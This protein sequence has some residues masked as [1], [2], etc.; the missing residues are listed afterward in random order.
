MD[1]CPRKL[2]KDHRNKGSRQ[3]CALRMGYSRSS[4]NIVLRLCMPTGTN[5]SVAAPSRI[6]L[7]FE[8]RATG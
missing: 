2:V 8:G 5:R 3:S 6:G 4:E 7:D 1:W